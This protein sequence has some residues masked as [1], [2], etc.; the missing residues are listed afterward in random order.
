MSLGSYFYD[1]QLVMQHNASVTNTRTNDVV[2]LFRMRN[3]NI[4][5][6]FLLL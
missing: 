6:N 3:T 2:S 4:I 5:I 1:G